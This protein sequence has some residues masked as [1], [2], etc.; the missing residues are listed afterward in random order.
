MKTFCLIVLAALLVT[1]C[2]TPIQSNLVTV[3]EEG[4]TPNRD[5]EKVK[6]LRLTEWSSETVAARNYFVRTAENLNADAI[7][8]LPHEYAGF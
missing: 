4:T 3:Y 5:F 6:L 2:E 7:I 8:M 1:G